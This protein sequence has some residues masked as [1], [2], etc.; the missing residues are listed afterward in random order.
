VSHGPRTSVRAFEAALR[1]PL[2]RYVYNRIAWRTAENLGIRSTLRVNLSIYKKWCVNALCKLVTANIDTGSLVTRLIVVLAASLA[3]SAMQRSGVWPSVCLSRQHI[4]LTYSPWL[5]RG[6]IRLGQLSYI[7]AGREGGPTYL[8]KIDSN[9]VLNG[10][11]NRCSTFATYL[12]FHS[13]LT[14]RLSSR[15]CRHGDASANRFSRR[16]CFMNSISSRDDDGW[17]AVRCIRR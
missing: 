11:S 16:F 12:G 14:V 13:V 17:A 5:T 4:P 6:S 9:L 15:R 2:P 7:S 8:S 10:A 1:K 3:Q